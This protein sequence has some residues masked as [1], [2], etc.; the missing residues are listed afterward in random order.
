MSIRN[1]DALFEPKTIVIVTAREGA[2][3]FEPILLR[4]LREAGFSHTIMTVNSADTID[5][6][7]SAQLTAPP[8][9]AIV[10]EHPDR[11]PSVIAELGRNGCRAAILI[12][13]GLDTPNGGAW[14]QN[15]L[16]AAKPSSMR[17]IGP[18][19]F[20]I[21]SPR[22]HLNAS[23]AHLMPAQG[24]MAFVSQSGAIVSAM[25]DWAYERGIGF[26]HIV[27]LGRMTDVD[28]GD[29]L[30]FLS[31]DAATRSILLYV[32]D[33]TSAR[34]FM[35]AA[36][37]AARS[38]PVLV[39]KP[40]VRLSASGAST[41]PRPL[42]VDSDAVYDAAFRRSGLL[43]VHGLEELFEAAATL[44]SR[45]R[46]AGDRLAILAN[47]HGP[48]HV[49]VDALERHGARAGGPPVILRRDATGQD[50]AAALVPLLQDGGSDAVLVINAPTIFADRMEIARAIADVLAKRAGP[51]V[52]ANWLGDHTAAAAR[53]FLAGHNIP[54]F[55]TPDEAVRAFSHLAQYRRNQELL[56][57]TPS[58]GLVVERPTVEQA[59]ALVEAARQENRDKL[60]DAETTS[61]LS[62]FGIVQADATTYDVPR[63]SAGIATDLTFGRVVFFGGD[64]NEDETVAL[65]P[66]NSVVAAQMIQRTRAAERIADHALD[67]AAWCDALSQLLVRLSEL[68]IGLPL[69][70]AMRLDL[71]LADHHRVSA[72]SAAAFLY[73][74]GESAPGLAILPYPHE[75]EREIV[76]RDGSRYLTRPIRPEDEGALIAMAAQ[77]T[78]EDIRLR[79]FRAIHNFSH[80]LA[81]R[82]SQIDYDREMAL[83]AVAVGSAYGEGP[84]YGIVRLVNDPG[85]EAAE[86]AVIVRSDMKGHGLGYALL[87]EVLDYARRRGLSRV[88]GEILREN[89]TMLRMAH[90]LGFHTGPAEAGSDTSHVIIELG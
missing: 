63:F 85:G 7:V 27:S 71:R 11:I 65:P 2:R 29:V 10:A 83:V 76:L 1:F 66:L 84:V 26:S 81:S 72:K 44:T 61:L 22:N 53:A 56:L 25:L 86:F 75:L 79:F 30:A 90:E 17:I 50:Y 18:D 32:E 15:A 68:L 73:R 14:L 88:Y 28:L 67:P 12:D 36:R 6:G 55:A 64:G 24:N 87:S 48:A 51:P 31:S 43:R 38:K 47:G 3:Q 89:T 80:D 74:Q 49:A 60:T 42:S 34:K 77:C 19:C 37:I 78:P 69:I 82:A 16:A 40:Q 8:D 23:C 70:K 57:Q 45:V 59:T 9:L 58:A 41:A 46:L 33:V 21:I 52:F 35:S 4:N 39:I 20:G 54:V 13:T 62:L 5:A